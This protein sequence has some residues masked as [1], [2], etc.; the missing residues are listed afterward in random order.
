MNEIYIVGVGMTQFG[1]LLDRTVY[2]MVNVAVRLALADAGCAAADVGSAY[3]AT[4][5]NGLFQGQ[6]AIPGP[7][8]MRRLG[9]EGIPVF[10]VENAC[11]SGSSA[12]NL[13]TLALRAG[14]CDIAL[15]VGAEKMNIPDKAKMFSAFDGG[16]DVSTVEENKTTLLAMGDGII[17]PPG[18]VSERPYS[19]FM[20]V[21]AA[22]C[23]NHMQ[24]YG[25]TQRQI[26]AVAAKN[27]RHSVHN[28][29]SQFREA[30]S[31]EQ[32]LASPPICYPL[33]TLMCSPIS[34]GA[35]AVVLCNAD[36]LKKLQDAKDRAIRVLASIVQTGSNRS[37]D[38]PYKIV[39]HLAAKKAYEQAGVAPSD[40]S[41]AEVHDASAI[42]EILNA[43]SLM[44]VPFGEG[45][46]AAER[47]DF[48]V[49]GRIPINPSGGLESKGH[50]IA[51]TGLGQI[52]ELVTQL[53][54]EAEQR[55]VS[56]AR[57]AI[58]EN[59]GGLFG[60]EEA[61]VVVNILAK[62]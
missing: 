9:I 36:G 8:A 2:D 7:I 12:F 16:W 49:G 52:H 29:L 14:S 58:Q 24:R 18:T 11:A 4:M 43:E 27:H 31:I 50:P 6:T 48:T 1:R 38:E 57:I 51:A 21:Y 15:A 55:Q 30:F 10:T 32:V 34:D 59:G 42:G 19:V 62:Q 28:P 23:R 20:D 17:P 39:A 61:V 47:G 35:A 33:T 56:N 45:G 25:T 13:A 26:A 5:T 22:I 40:V 3:Y 44:L 54:G 60:I 37:L 53:R 46:P 41:V